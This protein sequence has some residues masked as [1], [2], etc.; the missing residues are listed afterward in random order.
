M[1]NL[2]NIKN[3]RNMQ[4][5]IGSD[6]RVKAFVLCA[7]FAVVAGAPPVLFPRRSAASDSLELLEA[8]GIF[9]GIDDTETPNV[10]TLNVDG[11]KA[12]GPLHEDCV[13]YDERQRIIS[14]KVFVLSYP[15]RVVTVEIGEETGQVLSCRGGS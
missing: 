5:R 11:E 4:N 7:F 13:F 9:E 8:T 1:K 12:S 15:R 6:R 2:R 14:R 3:M 10:I